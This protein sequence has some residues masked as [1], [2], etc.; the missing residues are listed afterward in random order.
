[1]ARK[2]FSAADDERIILNAYRTLLRAC[3]PSLTSDSLKLVR[4]AFQ[5]SMEAHHGMRR[6]SG[7]P[8]I[9][10]P[11]EVAT[12]CAR[13]IG[14]GTKSIVAALLHDVVEDTEVTLEEIE[15]LFGKKI[16][17]IIDGLTKVSGIVGKTNSTQAENFKKILLTLA[18]DVRVIL[19]K[20]ADRL[21]NMRTLDSLPRNKQLKI[22]S[23]TLFLFA[24]L[25]HRLGLYAIKSELEDLSLKH[26]EPVTY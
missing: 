1:M 23:E 5:F 17:Q 4:K 25:A 21:H 22:A 11:V 8:Y 18:E 6:K 20:M 12:I 15:A 24:P 3:R 2:T 10:H 19:V 9:I 14:L 7:E 13:E 16:A 26:T